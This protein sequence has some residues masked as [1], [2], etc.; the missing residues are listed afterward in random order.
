MDKGGRYLKKLLLLIFT[1]AVLGTTAYAQG[2]YTANLTAA[3]AAC[4]TAGSCLSVP[5]NAT[6]G[7]ATFTL[8]GTFSAT[9]Q[10]EAS[11]DGGGT[12]VALNVV[13]SNSSTAVT[14]ATSAGVW[15]ANVAGYTNIRMRVSTYA[16][17]TVIAVIQL[18]SA[19]ARTLGG[20]GGGG[21]SSV[22]A[23]SPV[24]STGGATPNI[25]CATCVTSSSPDVGI[26]HFAGST[27]A[28]TSSAV[29]LAA[30]VT[31]Q[32]PI[33]AVGSAGLSGTSPIAIAATGVI[34][35]STCNTSSATIAGSIATTQVAFGSGTNT[36]AGDATFTFNSTSKNL[37]VTSETTGTSPPSLTPGTGG[38]KAFG[39][40]TAPTTNSNVDVCYGDSTA[41]RILCSFN[42]S[43]FVQLAT[44][45]QIITAT[46]CTSSA[47]PAVCGSSSAGAVTIAAGGPTTVVVDTNIV[48]VNSEI[49]V[50]DSP[51][52]STRL[53]VTCNATIAQP[54][55]TAISAGVSFTITIP[56]SPTTNPAC[57]DYL[58]VN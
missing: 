17:G 35:C 11:G 58:I 54:T 10:F 2:S 46:N 1:M 36:I 3:S 19:S 30:D 27:Q 23:T 34:S 4:A 26:A 44:T 29:N 41:H 5:V 43:G 39:E 6:F 25:A 33:G 55:V 50:M 7:G 42:N 31:G 18:S 9:V 13:P 57:Y 24:T 51:Y 20:G 28:V 15:Q 40:G 22:G 8:E 32:L 37:Q 48:S 45:N 14:S 21:V 49:F 56:V 47:S 52:L 12:W 16:S 53:A 38:M